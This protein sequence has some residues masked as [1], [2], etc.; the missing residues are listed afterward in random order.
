MFVALNWSVKR[1]LLLNQSKSAM[2]CILQSYMYFVW[3]YFLSFS[4]EASQL[5]VVR[6]TQ[7]YRYMS[8]I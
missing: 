4:S 2:R 3:F 7:M 5:V 8:A 6:Q 1:F